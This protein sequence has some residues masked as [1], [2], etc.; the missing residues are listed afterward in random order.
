VV[1]RRANTRARLLEAAEDVFVRKGLRG[2]TVDDLVGAAGFTRGAFYSNISS[3]DEVFFAVLDQQ[4]T[5][6]LEIVT[7]VTDSIPE[8]EFTMDSLGEILDAIRPLGLRFFALQTEFTLL[9]LRD[10]AARQIL[11][12]HRA[13]L[14]GRMQAAIADVV[15]RRGREPIVSMDLVSETAIALYLHSLGQEGLGLGVLDL[16]QLVEGVL[17]QVIIGLTREAE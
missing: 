5:R 6:L 12:E 8:G 7:E 1:R 2:V 17:P 3:I 11:E 4:S 13:R 15:R 10:P 16:R 14:D 9:A